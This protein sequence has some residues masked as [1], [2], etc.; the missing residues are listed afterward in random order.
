MLV[1]RNSE[2][3]GGILLRKH[4][5]FYKLFGVESKSAKLNQTWRPIMKSKM[6]RNMLAGFL[7][8]IAAPVYAV[9][10]VVVEAIQ[11]P[12]WV[13]RGATTQ[14][15]R[16]GMK[17]NDGDQL[18][19]GANARILLRSADGS[20]IKLG[21][22]ARLTLS[23]LK[24]QHE[25]KALFSA[26]LDVAKGAFRFTTAAAAKLNARDVKIKLANNRGQ[27]TLF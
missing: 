7:S 6:I 13:Q 17:L 4:E 27:T 19:A 16:V 25:G 11:M 12:A 21:E 8:L 1:G 24:Q 20:A 18:S 9:P 10:N 14:P 26:L 22:N 3:T 23:E 2:K 15:L 5:F